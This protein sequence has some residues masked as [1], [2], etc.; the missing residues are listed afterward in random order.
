MPGV[1][2]L[3]VSPDPVALGHKPRPGDRATIDLLTPAR[4]AHYAFYQAA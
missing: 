1:V 4:P 3:A 2:E